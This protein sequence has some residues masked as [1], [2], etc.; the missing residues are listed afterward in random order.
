MLQRSILNRR[1]RW[2]RIVL[3]CAAIAGLGCGNVGTR[4]KVGAPDLGAYD[5]NEGA[6]SLVGRVLDGSGGPVS[7]VEM[8]LCGTVCW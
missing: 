6:A 7:N 3:S 8:A 4:E 5:A 1:G 2:I